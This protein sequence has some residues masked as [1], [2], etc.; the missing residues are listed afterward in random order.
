MSTRIV[1]VEDHPLMLRALVEVLEQDGGFEVAG[2]ATSGAQVAPLVARA[3]PDLVLL[4][5]QIPG[6][7]GLGCLRQL[8]ESSSR[9]SVVV[10][11]GVES[12]ETIEQVLREGAAAF[13]S[14]SIDPFDLPA[15]LRAA[16][17]GSVYFSTPQVTRETVA[18][19]QSA[20]D[21]EQARRSTGLTPRELEILV[22]V[23][24]GLSNRAIGTELFLSDQT[25]KFHLN[26]IYKKL[27]VANRTEAA[28][29][30]HRLGLGRDLAHAR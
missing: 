26:R 11:S 6:L 3:R 10:F 9:A 1:V 29:Q 27:G 24:G 19:V 2:T 30:A 22:A 28:G 20:A 8:R 17:L 14:K 4:D 16:L 7:D 13:V 21:H 15:V 5:L 12:R 18:D 25:V 23:S